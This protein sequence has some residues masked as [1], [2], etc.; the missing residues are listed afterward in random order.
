VEN[1]WTGR[2]NPVDNLSSQI[3]LRA[4]QA[5][6]RESTRRAVAFAIP[7]ACLSA[8]G[9]YNSF[10]SSPLF[11][12]FRTKHNVTVHRFDEIIGGR[13]YQIEVTPVSNRWRAQ[14]RRRP[15][16][17]TAMMPFYG[18]TPDEAA[19]QLAQWLTLAHARMA[20]TQG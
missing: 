16:V 10:R 15:G 1:L 14:L 17:P 7:F 5:Q 8:P 19:R 20:V 18:Q 12:L 6:M 2:A 13:T 4:D 9:A 11:G 3:F